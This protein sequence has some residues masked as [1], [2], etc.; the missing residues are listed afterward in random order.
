M[1]DIDPLAA[2]S[3]QVDADGVTRDSQVDG[4]H[5]RGAGRD[6]V[7]PEIEAFLEE[8]HHG[9]PRGYGIDM[10]DKVI[11]DAEGYSVCGLMRVI[12]FPRRP[13]GSGYAVEVEF[14][15]RDGRLHRATVSQGDLTRGSFLADLVD[16]GLASY[17]A[18]PHVARYLM[19]WDGRRYGWRADQAGWFRSPEDGMSFV[20]ADG[21][22]HYA[23]RTTAERVVLVGPRAKGGQAAGSLQGWQEEVAAQAVGNP[24]LIFAISTA[25]AGP[26]LRI[27][28]IETVGV[29]L[30]GPSATGK[31]LLLRLAISAAGDP[32]SLIPW[33]AAETGLHRQSTEA[34]D[35]LLALDALPRDPGAK[36]L[37]ALLALGDDG[38]AGR[39]DA[40]RDPDGSRRFRRIVL[41]TSEL[42]VSALLQRKKK[43]SPAALALRMIDIP[44]TQG[45]HGLLDD[46]HEHSDSLTFARAL[47]A[48][49]RRRH[50][51]L[52][53][54]FLDHLVADLGQVTTDLR[55]A[56]RTLAPRIATELPP[57]FED[58]ASAGPTLHLIAERFALI[59]YA[60]EMATAFGLL[61]WPAGTARS[62]ARHMARLARHPAQTRDTGVTPL[63]RS[64]RSYLDRNADRII[65]LE[66]DRT[67]GMR[68]DTLGWRDEDHVYLR[69]DQARD[70]DDDPHAFLETLSDCGAL[71]P[72]GEAR[73]RQYKLPA[74]KVASRPRVYRFDRRMI[75]A[76][77]K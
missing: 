55:E 51:H 64:L 52:L 44:A 39:V 3:D 15:A 1:N 50:G 48:A 17:M 40:S 74:T 70:L 73:S 67:A 65:D 19:A 57:S 61:P 20:R 21:A 4:P 18:A 54:A 69:S 32:A 62:A 5:E 6:P 46:L 58:P 68:D 27:A 34:Q 12:S 71:K 31:S 66:A 75:E 49:M 24:A 72:G 35:G 29:N 7:S 22:V 63:L 47:E 11:L 42:P 16:H 9:L 76:E 45:R 41:S 23:D 13:D 8:L 33:S 53:P 60:G 56:L 59:G 30:F 10:D 28:G 26:L 43:S 37:K 14:L 38:G 25:L 2:M 36:L 77:G